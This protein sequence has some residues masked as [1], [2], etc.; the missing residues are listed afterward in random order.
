[1]L[2][3]PSP[4]GSLPAQAPGIAVLHALGMMALGWMNA[5]FRDPP[6]KT[7]QAVVSFFMLVS[8]S[9]MKIKVNPKAGFFK[10]LGAVR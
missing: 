10:G 9:D 5:S 8:Q 1:M 4:L 6:K 7:E 3:L 2:V